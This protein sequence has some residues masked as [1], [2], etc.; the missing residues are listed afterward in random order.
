M[1]FE[2]IE[3]NHLACCVLGEF[4]EFLNCEKAEC[5][6]RNDPACLKK[7]HF[8]LNMP[9]E[10]IVMKSEELRKMVGVWSLFGKQS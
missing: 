4:S 5:L 2:V 3:T 8:M 6:D 10:T 7:S 9:V 1:P